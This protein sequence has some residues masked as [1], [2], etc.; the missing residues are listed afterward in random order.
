MAEMLVLADF[1]TLVEEEISARVA[2]ARGRPIPTPNPD[3]TARRFTG[4][5]VRRQRARINDEEAVYRTALRHRVL[6]AQEAGRAGTPPPSFLVPEQA[7][8]LHQF[9]DFMKDRHDFAGSTE[10]HHRNR[11]RRSRDW[12]IRGYGIGM[13]P[14]GWDTLRNPSGAESLQSRVV[15]L[16]V[17]HVVFGD[18]P[19]R[20]ARSYESILPGTT[21]KFNAFI[22]EDDLVRIWI[23]RQAARSIDNYG[24]TYR[25]ND[26]PSVIMDL[27]RANDLPRGHALAPWLTRTLVDYAVEAELT[28]LAP[29]RLAGTTGATTAAGGVPPPGWPPHNGPRHFTNTPPPGLGNGS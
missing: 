16:S 7:Q 26:D 22:C 24:A 1:P 23:S 18:A 28:A 25:G 17:D 27:P 8:F 6:A 14:V 21:G 12:S 20:E 15:S 4:E 9:L 3:A 19:P 10:L 11:L 13:Y 2:I 29:M 5:D